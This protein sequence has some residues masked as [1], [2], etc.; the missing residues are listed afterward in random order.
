M[1]G[2]FIKEYFCVPLA[3]AYSY[4]RHV[5]EAFYLDTTPKTVRVF[6]EAELREAFAALSEDA[7]AIAY[8]R[9][10]EL[11]QR[12]DPTLID[13]AWA[14]EHFFDDPHAASS[15][16]RRVPRDELLDGT[17]IIS[18][19]SFVK[20][21]DGSNE[22]RYFSLNDKERSDPVV[23]KIGYMNGMGVPLEPV[24]GLGFTLPQYL[25]F[26]ADTLCSEH[27]VHAVYLPTCLEGGERLPL[28]AGE[29]KRYLSIE[30]GHISKACVLLVQSWI[31][32]LDTNEEKHYLHLAHSEG[33]AHTKGALRILKEK[34]P[35]LLARLRILTIA[36]ASFIFEEEGG[37]QV[38]NILKREDPISSGYG[39]G[40]GRALAGHP[41]T[42]VV[43][44]T[45]GN[46]H[47]FCE[48]DDF[49]HVMKPLIDHFLETGNL[50]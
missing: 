37:L 41:M 10:F 36:P 47:V 50:Y 39:T 2:T 33:A 31:D 38:R 4:L 42:L 45:E 43:E 9:R 6:D 40:A 5:D 32:Y 17:H 15:I 13:P 30:S 48:G 20:R 19:K 12:D 28:P 34:R 22:P 21:P 16:L 27:A 29:V 11:A 14:R 7:Q 1:A 35:D 18:C 24:E 44:H 26:I 8:K 49:T 46:P 25:T 23:G 3:G